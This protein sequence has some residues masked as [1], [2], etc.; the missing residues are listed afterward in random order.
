MANSRKNIPSYQAQG[1]DECAIE[2]AL[3][4]IGG[5]W[6]MCILK[7]LRV[8]PLRY[9]ELKRLVDGITEKMLIAQLRELEADGIVN[10]TMF[11]EIPPRVEYSLTERGERLNT[12]F[13]ALEDWGTEFLGGKQQKQCATTLIE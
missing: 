2:A 4:V 7:H 1:A 10:R 11:A 8:N 5:K 6:K 9:G 12:V 13:N 3:S